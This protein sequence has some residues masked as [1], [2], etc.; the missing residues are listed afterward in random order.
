MA[1]FGMLLQKIAKKE[2]LNSFLLKLLAN[3]PSKNKLDLSY[4]LE[5]S[6]G[7]RP[8]KKTPS[9]CWCLTE[10]YLDWHSLDLW[11]LPLTVGTWSDELWCV[12]DD[13]TVNIWWISRCKDVPWNNQ[14]HTLCMLTGTHA[15]SHTHMHAHTHTV[16]WAWTIEVFSLLQSVNN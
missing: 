2:R 9:F 13:E 16:F 6:L 7:K 11:M 1:H 15:H 14:T 10:T 12:I 8:R 4:L 3:N 5:E